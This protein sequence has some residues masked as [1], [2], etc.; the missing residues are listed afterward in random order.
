MPERS[1][2]SNF[3]IVRPPYES[4]HQDTLEWIIQ[5]HIQAE[6]KDKQDRYDDTFSQKIRTDLQRVGCKSTTIS[7]RGHSISDFLTTSWDTMR[8]YRL[9]E[10]AVGI[11]IEERQK[12]HKELVDTYVENLFQ[13]VQE[14]PNQ[15][16]H[17]SCTGYDS[18]NSCQRLVSKKQWGDRSQVKTVYHTGCSAA[19]P[20]I[21]I[22]SSYS[23]QNID[24]VHTELCSLHF[25]P[26]DHGLDQLVAQS[27]FADGCIKY[28]AQPASNTPSL[29]ILA[30][31]EQLI[32]SSLDAMSWSITHWGFRL[33]LLKEIP[34]KIGHHIQEFVQT[35]CKKANTLKIEK[36]IFAVHPG[37]PKILDQIQKAFSLENEQLQHSREIL[38]RYG[39][40]SSA[41]VPHIW[42]SILQDPNIT[43]GTP[44]ISLAFGPGLTISGALLQKVH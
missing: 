4:L 29:Q 36:A 12:I 31:H 16:I 30:V 19:I 11:G 43:H 40:M 13:N 23:K 39:N 38:K 17:V 37:G 24:I 42:D 33:Q 28:T 1:F 10:A 34:E 25:N 35:L 18:P 3:Q 14:P 9:Q 27:L 6:K 8:I 41:T 21:Q 22:A 20:A 32:P 15:I 26:L 7:T 2:L 5:A 44:I